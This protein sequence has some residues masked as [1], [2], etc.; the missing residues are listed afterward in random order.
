MPGTVSELKICWEAILVPDP[1]GVYPD[2]PDA[3]LVETVQ[4][5]EMPA[6][7][8]VFNA[9]MVLDVP[10]QIVCVAGA[11]VTFG[12]GCIYTLQQIVSPVQ[13]VAVGVIVY[14]T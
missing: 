5:N 10:E 8:V 11:G 7:M 4:E 1:A 13:L 3:G 2:N 14:F 12:T 9:I 6:G